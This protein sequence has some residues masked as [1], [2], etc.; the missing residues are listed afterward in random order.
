MADSS[1]DEVSEASVVA[2][3]AALLKA[4]A[5]LRAEDTTLFPLDPKAQ[6]GRGPR[7]GKLRWQ[8]E[9]KILAPADSPYAG[10]W[11]RMSVRFPVGYPHLP[12]RLQML[13]IVIHAEVELRD[14]YE[15][16]LEDVFYE[17][18]T[19]SR[20]ERASGS[21]D[22]G[23]GSSS[24]HPAGASRSPATRP[25]LRFA[26]G[27][28]VMCKVAP[29][30][31]RPGRVSQVWYAEEGWKDERV[32]PYQVALDDGRYIFAPLDTDSLVRAAAADEGG[33]EEKQEHGAAAAHDAAL[34]AA[35]E[36]RDAGQEAASSG[37]GAGGEGA[38]PP[39]FSV[40]G[41]LELLREAFR[42]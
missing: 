17:Q 1:P 18:L 9:C 14:P 33:G 40:R 35:L 11:Y 34:T 8:W 23:G 2:E 6:R 12:P 39:R 28:R 13:S 41:A 26:V 7:A 29:S 42:A 5:W 16:Q 22:G 15:G 36:A 31:W 3:I 21:A 19:A 4:V 20:T 32:A 10:E 38:A 24:S 30:E 37:G 25:P 27:A